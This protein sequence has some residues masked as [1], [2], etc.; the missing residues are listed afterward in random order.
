MQARPG[1]AYKPED[2]RRG[3]SRE[4]IVAH[5]AECLELYDELAED[6]ANGIP[7]EIAPSVFAVV[8]TMV[9]SVEPTPEAL[10][11]AKK[12]AQ[13]VGGNDGPL[14]AGALGIRR[15]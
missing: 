3:Y 6:R 7:P 10:E 8:Q 1:P 9:A 13:L 12:R 2:F 14:G 15:G 11:A 4:Q 5:L